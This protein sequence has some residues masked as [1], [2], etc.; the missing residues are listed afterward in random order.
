MRTKMVPGGKKKSILLGEHSK[1]KKI[2]KTDEIKTGK[3]NI[4]FN[5][6]NI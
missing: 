6:Y 4:Y 1:I 5:F 2:L 3:L